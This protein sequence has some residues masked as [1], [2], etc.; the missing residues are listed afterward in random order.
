[1]AKAASIRLRRPRKDLTGM[2]FGKLTVREWAT[3]S[4]WR[5]DCDCGGTS[6]V[7]T[8]NLKRANT[9]SCGCIRNHMASVRNTR[10]GMH[11]TLVYKTWIGV[12]RRCFDEKSGRSFQEYGARGITMDEEWAGDF[13][14]FLRDVGHPPTS[15]H[16]LDRIDNA[17]GYLP[18]NVRWATRIEQANNKRNN[19]WVI[20]RGERLTVAQ[21]ARKVA[22]EC[23]IAPGAFRRAFEKVIY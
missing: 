21:L 1:M 8:A 22:D 2:R 18:G 10:H 3:N 20:Y 14:A 9:T 5:C 13:A 6:I 11:G 19:R 23:G 16:T 12:R 17:K 4:R 15:E 7:L